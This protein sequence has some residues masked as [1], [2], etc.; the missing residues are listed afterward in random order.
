MS[1]KSVYF[2]FQVIWSSIV[3]SVVWYLALVNASFDFYGNSDNTLSGIFLV[4]GMGLYLILTVAY[5]IL[6]YKKISNW[7]PMVVI[8]VSVLIAA[9]AGFL[10]IFGAACGSELLNKL[11]GL[12]I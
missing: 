12:G 11:P 1:K 9:S 2:I 6:G 8:L 4:V 5:I 7:R 3:S 10:G